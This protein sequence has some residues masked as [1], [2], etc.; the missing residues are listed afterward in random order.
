[1]QVSFAM[2]FRASSIS[3]VDVGVGIPKCLSGV[4]PSVL[5]HLTTDSPV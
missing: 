1:M 5:V 2:S 4:A 3:M